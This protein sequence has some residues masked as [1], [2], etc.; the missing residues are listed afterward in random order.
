MNIEKEFLRIKETI[1]QMPMAEFEEM[2]IDC[3]FGSIRPSA[4]SFFC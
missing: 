2:L 1:V 4:E 3:G